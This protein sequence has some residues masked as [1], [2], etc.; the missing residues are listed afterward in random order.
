MNDSLC[1]EIVRTPDGKLTMQSPPPP[2]V[3]IGGNFFYSDENNSVINEELY[4]KNE[5]ARKP[6]RD[7]LDQIIK[8]TEASQKG[9]LVA[10]AMIDDWLGSWADGNAMTKIDSQQD[11]F[12]R[13]WILSGLLIAYWRNS[14]HTNWQKTQKIEKWLSTLTHLMMED[15]MEYKKSS[16]KNNHVYWA[17]LVAIEMSAINSDINLMNW[18]LEKVRFGLSQIDAEGFLPLELDRK[19]RALQYHRVSI[20]AL[21]MAAYF[22]KFQGIDLLSENNSALNRLALAILKGYADPEIFAAKTG[23]KQEFKLKEST[24]WL[25]VYDTLRPGNKQVAQL[26]E[27]FPPI[28]N[29]ALGGITK[30]VVGKSPT[31]SCK[32]A[33]R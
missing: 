19:G 20:E 18:G 12:E 32:K 11:G 14:P 4:K 24:A 17:G 7:Y 5:E 29:R 16:Q 9:D 27:E 8:M 31:N 25:A 2:V 6:L 3:S 21:M 22:A 26:L 23:V 15:Y 1:C 30:N 28:Q 13:K 33:F 10:G